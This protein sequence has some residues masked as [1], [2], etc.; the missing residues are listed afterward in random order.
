M[1]TTVV[2]T[3]NHSV[4][5]EDYA[6]DKD[7]S[8]IVDTQYITEGE[9]S[10]QE[11]STATILQGTPSELR[12]NIVNFCNN[13]TNGTDAEIIFYTTSGSTIPEQYDSNTV[14]QYCAKTIK[15]KQASLKNSSSTCTVA[16]IIDLISELKSMKDNNQGPWEA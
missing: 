9:M 13:A 14:K 15:H 3:E 4:D 5:S 16:D 6:S 1:N 7:T 8:T 12:T 11:F 2:V 10:I